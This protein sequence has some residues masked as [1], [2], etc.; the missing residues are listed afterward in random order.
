MFIVVPLVKGLPLRVAVT[1]GKL[2]EKF[3]VTGLLYVVHSVTGE[4]LGGMSSIR[5]IILV[6]FNNVRVFPLEYSAPVVNGPVP[7]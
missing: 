7:R 6:V 2:S 1:P 3:I 4:K 5:S